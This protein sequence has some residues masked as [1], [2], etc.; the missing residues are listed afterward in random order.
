MRLTG[1]MHKE[2]SLLDGMSDVGAHDC[3]ILQCTGEA[4]VV[5][6]SV[7]SLSSVEESFAR[8]SRGVDMGR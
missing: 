8:V 6:P 5:E 1:I 7:T 4:A 2:A 3:R